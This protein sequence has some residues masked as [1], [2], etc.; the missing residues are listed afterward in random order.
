MTDQDCTCS[1]CVLLRKQQPLAKLGV[2][3]LVALAEIL[4]DVLDDGRPCG[5]SDCDAH[6][7]WYL[8]NRNFVDYPDDEN[9]INMHRLDF[10]AEVKRRIVAKTAPAAVKGQSK[11]KPALHWLR[12]SS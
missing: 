6:H 3:D 8:D 2:R 11:L 1:P 12:L 9:T 5:D 10:I 7:P 4:A